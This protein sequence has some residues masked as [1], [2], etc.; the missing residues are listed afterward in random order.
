MA[1]ECPYR[2]H[3]SEQILPIKPAPDKEL[4]VAN[5]EASPAKA[6]VYAFGANLGIAVSK[7]FAAYFSGSSSMLAEAIHSYADTVNQLLL[8]LGMHRAKRPPDAEHPLGY[9]KLSYFWSFIVAL[10]LFSLGGVFSVYEGWHKLREPAALEHIWIALSVL[11]VAVV[12]EGFSMYGCLREVNK[13]RGR[14][15]LREWLRESRSSELVVVFGEDLAALSGLI[16]ALNCLIIA[17]VTGDTVFDAVGSIAIGILLIAVA[18]FLAV[19][20]KALLIGR[21][22]DPDL[23]TAIEDQLQQHEAIVRIYNVI[24]IQ[25][26]PQVMLAAKIR[27]REEIPTAE[28]CRQINAMEAA[29]RIRFPEIGWCFI[30]PD[31]TD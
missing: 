18:V 23:V 8:L 1:V 20:I 22:A 28:T 19:K 26:G 15:S 21:S 30:E 6:I 29:L 25:V 27:V 13:L 16:I 10:I 24:T 9:G 12:L 14:R 3:C 2:A 11:C 5:L 4:P 31:V 17:H 7:T